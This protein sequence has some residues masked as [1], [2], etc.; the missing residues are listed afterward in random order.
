MKVKVFFYLTSKYRNPSD[1]VTKHFEY[2]SSTN[3]PNLK[4]FEIVFRELSGSPAHIIETGTSAW[5]T[6]STR[7]WDRYVSRYGG[8]FQSV[9]IRSDPAR[10]LKGQ[11]GKHTRLVVSDSVKFLKNTLPTEHVD[12]F[13][14]DSWDVDWENPLESANHGFR[15]FEVIRMK[16]KAGCILFI[17]DTPAHLDWIPTE[18]WEIARKFEK[19]YGVLPGKG[20]FVLKIL[21]DEP[22]IEYLHHAYSVVIK[23]P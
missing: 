4:A 16:L 6:D 19:E 3:H 8:S 12:V 1:I 9:D 15:E 14:L 2:W 11:L 21:R 22:D 13:Y 5:G 18:Y 10:R 20:A 7:L 23:F 17:D